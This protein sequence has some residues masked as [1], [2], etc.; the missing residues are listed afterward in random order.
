MTSASDVPYVAALKRASET[1]KTLLAE[2]ARLKGPSPIAIV[3]IACRFPGG[4]NSPGQFWDLLADGRDAV[5]P[6]PPDRWNTDRWWDANPDS[7]GKL[8]IREGA[9]LD[10]VKGFDPAFFNMTP[11]EAQALDPQ[12]RLLLEMSW[13]AF[14]ASGVDVRRLAGSRAGVFIGLSNY[15]YIQAHIHSGDPTRIDAYSGSGAMFSTAAGR[16]A[17]FYDFKGPCLTVDTACSS[18]LVA[19]D[20]AVKSLRRG[21]CDVALAGGI[22]LILSPDSTVALCKVKALAADGR[23]RAFDD[24]ATGYGRGEGGGLLVL[25]RL[26]D[27]RRDGDRIQAVLAGSAVNHDGRSNGLTAPNGLAQ[28]QVIRDALADAGLSP[29]AIDYVEAHG[30]GTPLGDPIEFGALRAVFGRR[31]SSRPLWMGSV[32]TNIGHTEAAAGIA[33][34]IKVVLALRHRRLPKSL[35]FSRPNHHIDWDSA[36]IQVVAEARDWTDASGPRTAGIS[37]FGLSGTNAHVILTEPQEA[38]EPAATVDR[39]GGVHVLPLSAATGTALRAVAERWRERL[40]AASADEAADL[41]H[42]AARRPALR[43]RLV[44]SGRTVSELAAALSS[45]PEE[46]FARSLRRLGTRGVVFLFGGGQQG[47]ATAGRTLTQCRPSFRAA[48][49]RTDPQQPALYRLQVALAALWVGWGVRPAAVIGC[50]A[51]V[52]AAAEVAGRPESEGGTLPFYSATRDR[53]PEVFA[54]ARAAGYDTFVEIGPSADL[55]QQLRDGIGQDAG[56]LVDSLNP[57]ADEDGHIVSSLAALWENGIDIDWTAFGAPR[58]RRKVEAPTYPFQR[59]PYWLDVA[60]V[61]PAGAAAQAA[62]ARP[63]DPADHKQEAPSMDKTVRII[64]ELVAIVAEISG[65]PVAEIDPCERFSDMGLDSLMLVRLGQVVEKTYGVE[66][67]TSQLFAALGTIEA[68]ADHV[69]RQAPNVAPADVAAEAPARPAIPAALTAASPSE[70]VLPTPAAPDPTAPLFQQQLFY[71]SQVAA[72][73]LRSMH[74][75]IRQQMA[76]AGPSGTPAAPPAATTPAAARAVGTAKAPPKDAVAAIRGINLAGAKLS[77]EQQA[78]VARLVADHVARTGRSKSMTQDSRAVLAD[79]KHTLSF[80]GQMKEAKYPIVSARSDGARLWDVDGNEYIDVALGMG[81]HFFGHRPPF[82]HDALSR[83]MECGLELGTQS[84]LTG[85][86]AQLVHDLTGSERVAFGNTGSE[87]VMVAIRLARAATGRSRIVIFKNA[88]HGIFDGVLATEDDEGG[89]RPIGIG[90]P[91]AMIEDVMVMEYGAAESLRLIEQQAD[92]I[93]AVL[94]E[95]VQSRDPDLQPQGFLKALR[96]ITRTAGAAL[97]FDEMITGFRIL[98]GGAQAWFG[99]RADIVLYGKIVGGGMPIGVI[100][101]AARY[102]DYIDGGAWA[103]GDRSAP[104]S[105]MIYF[106]GTFCR[107]P[108]T[109]V[110]AHAALTHM[111]AE[112]PALQE[113]VTALT[114]AFCDRLNRWFETR[115]VPLRAKHF[116]SQ[117]RLV[118]LGDKDVQPIELELLYLAMIDRGVYTWERRISF[119]STAHTEADV[120]R[121]FDVLT[122]C[123]EE[124]RAGGFA[125]SIEAYPEPQFTEPSSVQRRLYALS[126]R[127]GGQLPYHLPQA[128][129]IDGPLDIERLET[130]FRTI[131]GRHESLRT[132]FVTIEGEL[133][134]KR[135]AEPRFEIER[136]RAS[137]ADIDAAVAAFVRPFDLAVAPLLRVATV[138][139]GPERQ[140][141]LADAHHIVADGL[142]C[143]VIAAELMALYQGQSLAPV[144]Y[145]WRLC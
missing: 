54:A 7:P 128:F 60:P 13:E 115:R 84:K 24:D 124:I 67:Q 78:F 59:H 85:T 65:F 22:S 71:L 27:A 16:L 101:G 3:G 68:L 10:D 100:A 44:V 139:V 102:L 56:L 142:S 105:P 111:T 31:S 143:N 28:Q 46:R 98:P 37:S 12:Q 136:L 120:E 30:T 134:A 25:K 126:Q 18:S 48:F 110:T 6:V 76:A 75:L 89:V 51:G 72:Q 20:L 2:N 4:A 107:N 74:E 96:R 57:E 118:P 40:A 94:V 79:W 99:V 129:W 138:E 43:E 80:W 23:S 113:R 122:G 1:I 82:I 93:A 117:W 121:V 145:D 132:S 90:T 109:M 39:S 55:I 123:I 95:P 140:L 29:D 77:T 103:Y 114:T 127:E 58:P 19:L 42:A 119:F 88:Y 87:A 32:K 36:S 50:E 69:I 81:V 64:G 137:E 33:G 130:A 26:D 83:Q 92:S 5:G 73:N 112:G 91:P 144:D 34:V 108:A 131:I 86:V 116:A 9:F 66:A 61:R 35:H 141:L 106:G 125:W 62:P 14:D 38:E 8:Y 47:L 63:A 70:P 49:E 133:L 15:D 17:Y 53:L 104:Q 97:I 45:L 21:E 11:K 41:C 135:W 52:K